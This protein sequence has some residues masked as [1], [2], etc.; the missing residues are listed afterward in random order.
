MAYSSPRVGL[1]STETTRS[2]VRKPASAAGEF[3]RTCFTN[4][5]SIGNSIPVRS[6]PG[7]ICTFNEYFAVG[8]IFLGNTNTYAT[9]LRGV[10]DEMTKS[11]TKAIFAA[12]QQQ[13]SWSARRGIVP[14]A[15]SCSYYRSANR[16]HPCTSYSCCCRRRC[17]RRRCCRC[18]G[19]WRTVFCL[20]QILVVDRSPGSSSRNACFLHTIT[21]LLLIRATSMASTASQVQG[22]TT[23]EKRCR[24]EKG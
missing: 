18:R 2:P 11:K 10:D 7:N 15:P 1:P 6:C 5:V 17:C 22:G 16:S 4:I 8:E 12:T 23:F 3:P 21:S 20:E 24:T 19:W 14:F 9:R 13:S